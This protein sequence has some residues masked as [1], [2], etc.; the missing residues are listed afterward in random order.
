M[1]DLLIMGGFETYTLLDHKKTLH[2][3]EKFPGSIMFVNIDEK[4]G[5]K[6]WEGYIR[7]MLENPRTNG[8]RLGILSYNQD[9]ALMEK[10]LMR[11]CRR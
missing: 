6:E 7:G 3:L 10:Y 8:T 5:E 4:M 9:R 2:L 11:P 1:I